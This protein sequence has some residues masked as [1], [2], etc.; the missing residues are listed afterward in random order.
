MQIAI[1]RTNLKKNYNAKTKEYHTTFDS[2]NVSCEACHAP[3]SNHILWTKDKNISNRGFMSHISKSNEIETCAKCHSRR[4]QL[5]DNFVA[6]DKFD[7]HYLAVQLEEGL[8][9][10][11]G[12]IEDEVY[13]YDSFIQSKMYAKGVTCSDCHNP[14]SLNRKKAGDGVCFGC[15]YKEKSTQL[16]RIINTKRGVLGLLV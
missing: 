13:V 2:I 3:A 10:A 15:S 14:H 4:S 12:K 5:D 11:D 7:D 1:V 6:G 8:Y 9:F 16:H